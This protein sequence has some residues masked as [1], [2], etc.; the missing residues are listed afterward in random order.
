[1]QDIGRVNGVPIVDFMQTFRDHRTDDLYI[2]GGHP[3]EFGHRLMAL[4]ILKLLVPSF[5]P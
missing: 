5:C 4:E 2:D 1:M 3:T